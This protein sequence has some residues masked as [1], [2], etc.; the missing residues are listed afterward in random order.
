MLAT[1][2]WISSRKNALLNAQKYVENIDLVEVDDD[3]SRPKIKDILPNI[4]WMF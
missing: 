3:S 1:V 4:D 2:Y